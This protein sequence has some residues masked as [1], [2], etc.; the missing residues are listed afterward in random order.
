MHALFHRDLKE[1]S[2]GEN[3]KKNLFLYNVCYAFICSFAV[4]MG[5]TTSSLP[6]SFCLSL[7][8]LCNATHCSDKHRD[9]NNEETEPLPIPAQCRKK[10]L[11]RS[12]PR[13]LT[14]QARGNNS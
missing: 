9:I 10:Q 2:V 3:K 5:K 7:P 1:S 11:L 14:W 13:D 8:L 6:V 4:S 12:R